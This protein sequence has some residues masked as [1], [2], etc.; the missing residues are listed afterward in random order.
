MDG[1]NPAAGVM[2]QNRTT[3]GVKDGIRGG[4]KDGVKGGVKDGVKNLLKM[5]LSQ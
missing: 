3:L 1:T 2:H 5:K 4:V